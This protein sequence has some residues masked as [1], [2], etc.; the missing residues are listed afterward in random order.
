MRCPACTAKSVTEIFEGHSHCSGCHH[1]FQTDL[2]PTVDY[3]GQYGARTYNTYPE[4]T[5]HLRAGLILGMLDPLRSRRLH[6]IVDVGYGNGSF[7]KVMRKAGWHVFGIDVHGVDYG[8]QS[9]GFQDDLQYDVATFFDSLE[10]LPDLDAALCLRV[11]HAIVSIPHRPS[12][13]RQEPQRW[14]H[15]KPGEHLHYFTKESL[16]A[17]WRR[18]GL[19][20]SD[21]NDYEDITRG[22]A[23][24]AEPNIMT[25]RFDRDESK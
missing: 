22:R 19:F 2:L 4:T 15:F 12:W 24:H 8:I 23:S 18:A 21:M 5:S 13:F 16:S 11:R 25:Y 9:V 6:T 1:I 10:H 14:K 17:L 20:L 3:A 7:L